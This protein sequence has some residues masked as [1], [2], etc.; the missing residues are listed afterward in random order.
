MKTY[1]ITFVDGLAV[2]AQACDRE[3]AQ[4]LAI[5]HLEAAGVVHTAIRSIAVVA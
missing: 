4:E 2:T 1:R 3:A 5:D